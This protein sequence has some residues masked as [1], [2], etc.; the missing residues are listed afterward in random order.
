[1][2][3]KTVKTGLAIGGGVLALVL[4]RNAYQNITGS[5]EASSGGGDVLGGQ[6]ELGTGAGAST[7]AF[8]DS[9]GGYT[10]TSTV[11]E[12]PG[13]EFVVDPTLEG[14]DDT[15]SVEPEPLPVVEP[16]VDR[17]GFNSFAEAVGFELGVI[18][19]AAGVAYGAK[20]V[21]SKIRNRPRATEVELNKNLRAKSSETIPEAEVKTRLRSTETDLPGNV[22]LKGSVKAKVG[23]GIGAG[24]AVVETAGLAAGIRERFESDELGTGFTGGVKKVGA[25]VVDVGADTF[26]FLTGLVYRP[27]AK[28]GSTA[29]ERQSN[30]G[31][32]ATFRDVK[33]SVETQGVKDTALQASGVRDIVYAVSGKDITADDE[34]PEQL[35]TL[36]PRNQSV[37]AQMSFY[38]PNYQKSGPM[39]TVRQDTQVG[40]SQA[41]ERSSKRGNVSGRSLT[42]KQREEA[43][44]KGSQYAKIIRRS[45]RI[46]Y[47]ALR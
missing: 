36:D 15:V 30:T 46:E 41:Q 18:G 29:A 45:G 4:A 37:Q 22:K 21:V 20:K 1:M 19:T 34:G 13:P 42:S 28:E 27:K 43:G 5:E 10:E 9:P 44:R 16:L 40:R 24:A 26:G 23:K 11:S 33:E 8:T 6:D 7:L 3:N 14:S 2:V 31:W 38:N 47:R 32:F 25:G 35:M 17:E 39:T 12:G